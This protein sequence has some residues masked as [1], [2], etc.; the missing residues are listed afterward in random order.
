[1]GDYTIPSIPP[2]DFQAAYSALN[3]SAYNL[4]VDQVTSYPNRPFSIHSGRFATNNCFSMPG[5]GQLHS[6]EYQSAKTHRYGRFLGS[7][8]SSLME[9]AQNTKLADFLHVAV[10]NHHELAYFQGKFSDL[11]EVKLIEVAHLAYD[12]S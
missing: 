2:P 7:P 10:L 1:M 11:S 8:G 4:L 5:T 12:R 9:G 3:D 6:T